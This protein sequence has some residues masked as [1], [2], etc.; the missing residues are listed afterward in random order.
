MEAVDFFEKL[1]KTKVSYCLL[2][3]HEL[4]VNKKKINDLDIFIADLSQKDIQLLS[5]L[6]NYD[7]ISMVSKRDQIKIPS[8]KSDIV[9]LDIF[10]R[11]TWRGFEFFSSHEVMSETVMKDNIYT[12]TNHA[13]LCITILK[14]L[15]HNSRLK[16]WDNAP[17][18]AKSMLCT[19]KDRFRVMLASK[20][21]KF[22]CDLIIDR[23]DN[24][25][26]EC[27]SN[28]ASASVNIIG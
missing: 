19:D 16:D 15:L 2:R 26:R 17:G 1:N 3:G 22:C 6:L 9:E 27:K 8:D 12:L 7:G 5:R 4:I 10:R 20:V 28:C 25:R 13:E 21:G 11:I 24:L 14:E 18:K 23:I